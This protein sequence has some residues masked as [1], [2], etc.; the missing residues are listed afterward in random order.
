MSCYWYVLTLLVGLTLA[1]RCCG[2]QP[3]KSVHRLALSETWD[4][5][6]PG[7]LHVA[8]WR[9]GDTIYVQ[10]EGRKPI[11]V[12]RDANLV[13]EPEIEEESAGMY[14]ITSRARGGWTDEVLI[15]L[16]KDG[17]PSG[18]VSVFRNKVSA[19][20]HCTGRQFHHTAITGTI[21]RHAS[22]GHAVQLSAY[23]SPGR[24]SDTAIVRTK[25]R[26]L[27]CTIATLNN[28]L[29]VAIRYA[30]H[31]SLHVFTGYLAPIGSPLSVLT[32]IGAGH[33]SMVAF[34]PGG[35][36]YALLHRGP[37]GA[38]GITRFT[39]DGIVDMF[40]LPSDVAHESADIAVNDRGQYVTW[41][42][43]ATVHVR[44]LAP[45]S[46]DLTR[47]VER[48]ALTRSH[49]LWDACTVAAY[50]ASTNTATFLKLEPC[51]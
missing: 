28:E 32:T 41:V 24:Q 37:S 27:E 40:A 17:S 33:I 1:S 49:G 50:A 21:G 38:L 42:R 36:H 2:G 5:K 39:A 29:A 45:R 15:R 13:G 25:T 7:F 14:A 43:G 11:A 47:R 46:P 19:E 22:G 34:G 48:G 20:Q 9:R 23:G 12:Y 51:P 10:T 35:R 8:S 6:T 3:E 18:S 4:P 31:I 16:E 44:G 26:P 30:D